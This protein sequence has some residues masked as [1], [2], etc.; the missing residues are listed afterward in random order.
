[1]GMWFHRFQRK[2]P[3][4]QVMGQQI[5]DFQAFLVTCTFEPLTETGHRRE[6]DE[7][8]EIGQFALQLL[9][10]LLDCYVEVLR[11]VRGIS[12]VF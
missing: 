12:R 10:H 2:V 9:H 11:V 6:G 7:A 5:G 3:L 8:A 4:P 1:M